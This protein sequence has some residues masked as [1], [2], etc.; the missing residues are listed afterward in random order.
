MFP[1]VSWYHS[2]YH[3]S[4]PLTRD[5]KETVMARAAGDARFREALLTE[6]LEASL[7]GDAA[8]GR[9]MLRDLVNA[10]IGF[11]DLATRTG[12]AVKSLHRM[13]SPRG[14][15]T[16][17]NF[18]AI[19]DALRRAARVRLRVRAEARET[20]DAAAPL[21][22]HERAPAYRRGGRSG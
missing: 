16:S 4:V 10:T 19:V 6:A 11:D 7:A 18:F 21:T 14:N 15:P 8:A 20:R 22:V 5:F 13:L 1:E 9:A 17:G 3:S 12:I 2:C